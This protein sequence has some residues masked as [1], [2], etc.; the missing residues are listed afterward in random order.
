MTPDAAL[1]DLAERRLRDA[2]QN[3]DAGIRMGVPD[4]I[5]ARLAER[6]LDAYRMRNRV[7]EGGQP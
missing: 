2:R 5:L 7:R 4:E 3:V 1:L 6:E